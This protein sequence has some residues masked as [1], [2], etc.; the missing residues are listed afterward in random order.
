MATEGGRLI[1]LLASRDVQTA[2]QLADASTLSL[3]ERKPRPRAAAAISR[4]WT[5]PAALALGE[6]VPLV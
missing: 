6:Q 3:A 4:A 1:L 2:K 5:A